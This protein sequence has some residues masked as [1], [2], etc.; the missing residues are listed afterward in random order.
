MCDLR[1]QFL[2][3][4]KIGVNFLRRH[5]I[6]SFFEWNFYYCYS[7]ESISKN[8][9]T[10]LN[11]AYYIYTFLPRSLDSYSSLHI[12]LYIIIL[13]IC[14]SISA[15]TIE[16][17]ATKPRKRRVWEAIFCCW[18]QSTSIT[19][20]RQKSSSQNGTT[21]DINTQTI[22]QAAGLTSNSSQNRYLLP[23]IRHSDMHKKC[24]VIDLDETLVHS[25]FKVSFFLRNLSEFL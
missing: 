1:S 2:Y 22:G 7:L 25:S 16:E 20:R 18:R 19:T 6:C 21:I 13:Y 17:N 14:A 9:P 5:C 12:N 15:S 10:H 11:T 23:Q 24:M 3:E 4:K 8:K